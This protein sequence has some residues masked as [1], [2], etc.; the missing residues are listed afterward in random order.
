MQTHDYVL[1]ERTGATGKRKTLDEGTDPGA[2]LNCDHVGGARIARGGGSAI[3]WDPEPVIDDADGWQP[4]AETSDGAPVSQVLDIP[5]AGAWQISLAYDSRR[6]LH[7]TSPDLGIDTTVV[8]NLDF[9]GETPTFPVGDVEVS[10]PTK[11]VVT[12]EPEEPNLLARLLRAPN[13]AHLRSLTA[14]PTNPD[15]IRR[16]PLADACGSYVDWYRTG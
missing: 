11:A 8:A 2:E 6:P 7:V 5:R 12:V 13:E 15:A 4:S 16:V 1:Y 3:V 9:R 10:G 14:T